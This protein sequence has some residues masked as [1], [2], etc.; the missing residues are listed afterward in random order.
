MKK[1]KKTPDNAHFDTFG[2]FVSYVQLSLV[3][4]GPVVSEKKIKM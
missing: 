3:P 1:K 4:I 2:P